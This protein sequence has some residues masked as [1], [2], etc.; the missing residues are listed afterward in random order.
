ME[1]RHSST[2]TTP[3]SIARIAVAGLLLNLGLFPVLY[4]VSPIV[5]GVI[6]GLLVKK[7]LYALVTGFFP[8][9]ASYLI[10]FLVIATVPGVHFQLADQS[11]AAL[12]MGAAGGVGSLSAALILRIIPHNQR[13]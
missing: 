1:E 7:P 6:V 13:D 3:S 5:T 8:A 2:S 4:V 12:L 10:F 11:V 9:F